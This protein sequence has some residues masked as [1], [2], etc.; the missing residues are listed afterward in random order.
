MV[1]PEAKVVAAGTKYKAEMFI[2]ASSSGVTPTMAYNGSSIPVT[3]GMGKVEFTAQGGALIRKARC[4]G[5]GP[6]LIT[7]R[8]PSGKESTFK[9]TEEY[10]VIKRLF[11]YSLLPFRPFMPIAVTN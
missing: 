11:R 2:A 10:T 4:K 3:N 7:I 5:H 1:R 8:T 6:V 9:V